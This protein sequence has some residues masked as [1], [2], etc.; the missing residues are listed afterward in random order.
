M[1]LND[2]ILKQD[3]RAGSIPVHHNYFIARRWLGSDTVQVQYCGH[4]SEAP[5]YQFN[6][7][8]RVRLDKDRG[9]VEKL[10]QTFTPTL[11]RQDC[12]F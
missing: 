4:T 6:L 8:Y 1:L 10:H 11:A 3:A 5:V 2:L 9:K 7:L 12:S